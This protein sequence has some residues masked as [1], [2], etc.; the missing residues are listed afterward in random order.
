[1]TKESKKMLGM[2]KPVSTC[3]A[4]ATLFVVSLSMGGCSAATGR[5]MWDTD[6]S[7][8]RKQMAAPVHLSFPIAA[9]TCQRVTGGGF[10]LAR[11]VTKKKLGVPIPLNLHGAP[12]LQKLAQEY[13]YSYIR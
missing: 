9:N 10:L 2:R 7:C 1:M 13:N 3:V 11:F 6:V 12:D 8:L 4:F 5:T